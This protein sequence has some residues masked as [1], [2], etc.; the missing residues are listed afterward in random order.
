[1]KKRIHSW[2]KE[3]ISQLIGTKKV[4]WSTFI[5]GSPI[6]LELHKDFVIANQGKKLSRGEKHN[7]TL[8]VGD[9]SYDA[10]LT[11]IDRKNVQSDSL[12]LRYDNNRDFKQLL[13]ET[14]KYSYKYINNHRITSNNKTIVL[15][16]EQAEYIEFYKTEKP[17]VYR[18]VF[19]KHNEKDLGEPF[20]KIFVTN[21]VAN[22]TFDFI[23][24]TLEKLG[25]ESYEDD[26][27]S[28]TYRKDKNGL[29]INYCSWIILGFYR[30][31][32]GRIKYRIPLIGSYL[33][34]IEELNY[35]S[36]EAFFKR[37]DE[38]IQVF[39]VI[40]DHQKISENVEVWNAFNRTLDYIKERFSN[41]TIS[42][43]KESRNEQ[44][45]RAVYDRTYRNVLLVEGLG[46]QELNYWWVN[47]GQTFKQEK[48]G[49][50]LWAPQKSKQG[51]PLPHH[52]NLVNPRPGDFV[53][54]YS[55]RELKSIG[56][57][58]QAAIEASKPSEISS[59]EW[60][61]EGYLLKLDY[62]DFVPPIGKETIPLEWRLNEGGPF[63]INGNLKQGYFF[64]LTKEFARKL[65]EQFKERVPME[66]KTILNDYVS[67]PDY[68][69]VKEKNPVYL[70]SK[71]IVN[72]VDAYIKSK[73]FYYEKEEVINLFLSLKTKPF[74]IISGISGTGKTKIV[75]W[76]AESVG[77]TEENGQFS[78]IPIRPD[79]N[80]GS[81]LLGYVDIKGDFKERP[82]TKVILKAKDNPDSP[83]FVLLDEMNLARVEYYFSDILS[84]MESRKWEN[85]E[86]VSSTL[87]S[88]EVYGSDLTLPNNLFIIGTVNMDETTH[89]F[90]KKVLD[91]ANTIELNRVN[92]DNLAFLSDLEEVEPKVIGQERFAS[93]YLHL[94]DV[95]KE[96]KEIVTRATDE[97]VRINESLQLINAHV[98]YRV[99][100][101]ICFYL[102]YNDESNLMKFENAFDHCI[103]QKILPRIAGSDT[104]VEQLLR[105][106]YRQFT[107][108]EYEEDQQNG[109]IDIQK[110]KY[111]RSAAKV[112]EMLG[113]LR[114]DGFT[115][116]WIS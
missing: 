88:S 39:T 89:P 92:L 5:N 21:E 115:S 11:N 102:A 97:L 1:M 108:R 20:R 44:L 28:I 113:R 52:V 51:I 87:L 103:L 16:D 41:Q 25:V 32:K 107:N 40:F 36:K 109:Q 6:P 91:R 83:Y 70:S 84:V 59:H 114:N 81:D 116:F 31:P 22:Q 45:A 76:F 26:R 110:A 58:Q 71:E 74:V 105:G 80:D 99:R 43:Y 50:F 82:L 8:V 100:D 7:V 61:E 56:V 111:P 19:K 24:D 101:E 35:E 17:F 54:C 72:H 2:S 77:A 30:S 9:S 95:Y 29:H 94:K 38:E 66:V 93:K 18:V 48:E 13:L 96:N 4:D 64:S 10:Y 46:V 15:P 85:G 23:H 86:V 49:G 12:Q 98:G 106:L 62:F 63:D 75:Q 78:L 14:F 27:L 65:L 79:W 67:D 60:Q 69:E 55:A 57:V 34:T 112:A 90:S 37:K 47:Q 3:N 33:E 104:R 53:F 68:M 73:G 42:Q